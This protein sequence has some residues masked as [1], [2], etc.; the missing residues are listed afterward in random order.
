MKLGR[1]QLSC[2]TLCAIALGHRRNSM[3]SELKAGPSTSWFSVITIG[4]LVVVLTGA[5][6]LGYFD[7]KGTPI[8][9][10][11]WGDVLAGVF[12]PLAFL[13]LLYASLSQRA[14][15]ELQREELRQNNK[16]QDDQRIEMQKQVEA[17]SAQAKLL[18]AQANA[19]YE[20]VFVV[21]LM[22]GDPATDSVILVAIKNKGGEILNVKPGGYV[23]AMEIWS[24]RDDPEIIYGNV[25]PHW[26]TGDTVKFTIG[27]DQP[28]SNPV[29]PLSFQRLDT[30]SKR[31]DYELVDRARRLELTGSSTTG[32]LANHVSAFL[33]FQAD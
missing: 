23:T 21:Q 2:G 11:E 12:S 18:E 28:G 5:W 33:K 19:T 1:G 15:L 17:L 3:G 14:E 24:R 10:N 16:T 8:S 32:I 20:P 26:P 25:I 22:G 13:W 30:T 7:P 29:L 9:P 4:Y 27:I 31:N 6:R